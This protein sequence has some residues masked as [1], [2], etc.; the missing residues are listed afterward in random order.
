MANEHVIT[1]ST[2]NFEQEAANPRAPMLVDFRAS[3]VRAGEVVGPLFDELA[4]ENI[5][6]IKISKVNVDDDQDLATRFSIAT[7]PPC[8]CSRRYRSRKRSWASTSEKDLEKKLASSSPD[9]QFP[10]GCKR[11]REVR[12]VFNAGLSSRSRS[13]SDSP[14]RQ[15]E[16]RCHLRCVNGASSPVP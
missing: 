14:T 13:I 7:S 11:A 4:G 15:F 8:C 2:A 9:S 12:A 16:H 5:D 10:Q 3:L 1:L 6:K